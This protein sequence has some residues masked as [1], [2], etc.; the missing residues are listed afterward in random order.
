MIAGEVSILRDRL[1][2]TVEGQ[3]VE[4]HRQFWNGSG[5]Q[6]E[7]VEILITNERGS[8]NFSFPYTG[9]VIPGHPEWT[10]EGGKWR[11]LVHFESADANKPYF[12]E[13]WLNSTPEI[14]LGAASTAGNS[15]IWTTQV[16]LLA[17]ISLSWSFVSR[18]S[19]VQQL[20]RE[21]KGRGPER[22]SYRCTDVL[23]SFKQLH[24]GHLLMLQ[25]PNQILQNERG[26]EE[27]IRDHQRVRRCNQQN[28]RRNCTTRGN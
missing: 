20:Q 23:E 28:A 26:D 22:N 21:E 17:G 9:E 4:F 1:D 7:R 15:G 8:A 3:R 10:A 25:G 14:R 2:L 16:L 13:Q 18:C 27:G 24:R 5:W 12:V 6:T 11:V 19:D